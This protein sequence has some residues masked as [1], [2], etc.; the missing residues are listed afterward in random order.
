ML[1]AS[2]TENIFFYGKT[3][4]MKRTTLLLI[5]LITTFLSTE[6]NAQ[7]ARQGEFRLALNGGYSLRADRADP[8]APQVIQDYYNGQTSGYNYGL[9][10]TYMVL[11]NIGVGL[12]FNLDNYK[13]ELNNVSIPFAKDNVITSL[14]D[15]IKISFIGP[16]L[17]YLSNGEKGAFSINLGYGFTT[18]KNASTINLTPIDYEGKTSGIA[19]DVGYEFF[20]AERVSI[21]AQMSL[22]TGVIDEL[23]L[24]SGNFTEKVKLED[25]DLKE[26]VNR[27]NYCL[28]LR[29]YL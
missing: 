2:F 6:L 10:F 20:I 26:G 14:S 28:G 29:F 13:G 21:G 19:F 17:S 8:N 12:K 11:K 22:L 18:Y 24:K 4:I 15:D 9:D 7:D 25:D 27:A 1:V 3:I 23:E 5:T 16:L